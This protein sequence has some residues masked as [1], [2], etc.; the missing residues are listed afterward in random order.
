MARLH[1]AR[2]YGESGCNFSRLYYHGK[3]HVSYPVTSE[4]NSI[5]LQDKSTFYTDISLA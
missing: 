3:S 5:N 2:K 4:Y 1:T